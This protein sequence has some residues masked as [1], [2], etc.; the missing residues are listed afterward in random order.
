MGKIALDR[1]RWHL[2][3]LGKIDSMFE[4]EKEKKGLTHGDVVAYSMYACMHVCMY[5]WICNNTPY[6]IEREREGRN[7]KTSPSSRRSVYKGQLR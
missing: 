7:D 4:K 6:D 2:S 1:A 5:V 3:V